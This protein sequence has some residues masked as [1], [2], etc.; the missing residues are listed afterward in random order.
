MKIHITSHTRSWMRGALMK[1]SPTPPLAPLS[2]RFYPTLPLVLP[3][4][5]LYAP[6]PLIQYEWIVVT[7]PELVEVVIAALCIMGSSYICIMIVSSL[8]LRCFKVKRYSYCVYSWDWTL[9]YLYFLF[10]LLCRSLHLRHK[11]YDG[12]ILN[13]SSRLLS[14]DVKGIII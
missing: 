10:I 5:P 1:P 4:P 11:L 9:L 3:Q 13:S 14:E 8:L 6:I 12:I 7:T 2:P